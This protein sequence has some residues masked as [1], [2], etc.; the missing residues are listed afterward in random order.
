MK[1]LNNTV[2]KYNDYNDYIPIAIFALIPIATV[3]VTLILLVL[4]FIELFNI[5]T[6]PNHA[7]GLATI[8]CFGF[9]L[10]FEITLLAFLIVYLCYLGFKFYP[11]LPN[12]KK[13]GTV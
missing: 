6:K 1:L 12:K 13:N 9:F 11:L 10:P 2:K 4:I 3:V 5:A 8:L 7:I